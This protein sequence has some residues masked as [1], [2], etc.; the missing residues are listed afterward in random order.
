M[1]YLQGKD[2]TAVLKNLINEETQRHDYETDLTI[3]EVFRLTGKGAIDFGGSEYKMA[4]RTLIEPQ[5]ASG[6]A[7]YGWWDLE[8][9]TYMIS[10]NEVSRLEVGQIAFVQ[11][12]ERLQ[13]AGATHPTFYY[14]GRREDLKTLLTVG[15]AG[16]RIK[17][18]ARISKLL[19]LQLDQADE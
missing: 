9:G 16:I 4:E 6:S 19:I 11:P 18:N 12:H 13:L 2:V 7:K 14:R 10:F 3:A 15:S 1:H 17:E 8:I 5:K